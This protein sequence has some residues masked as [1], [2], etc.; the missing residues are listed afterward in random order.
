MTSSAQRAP[1]DSVPET[2]RLELVR[3][4]SQ[5]ARRQ[6][7]QVLVDRGQYELSASDP[8]VW[9]VGTDVVRTLLAESVPFEWLTRNA[10]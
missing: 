4:S 8:N 10:T 5:A 7:I 6:A 2:N 9:S 1:R 3:F